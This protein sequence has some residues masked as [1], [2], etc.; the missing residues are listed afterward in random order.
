MLKRMSFADDSEDVLPP[1]Y[2]IV[3]CA[4]CGLTYDDLPVSSEILSE[5][6]RGATKYV[7]PHVGG[8]G[9]LSTVDRMRYQDLIDFVKPF[10]PRHDCPVADVGCGKG[11]LLRW[12]R[13]N[14]FTDVIGFEPSLG[15]VEIMRS[16]DI[17]AVCTDIAHLPG[18]RQY[19]LV[20]VSNV[21]E[22]LLAP[23]ES[24]RAVDALVRPGGLVCVEVPDGSRYAECFMAPYYSFDMEHINHFDRHALANLWGLAGYRIVAWSEYVGH[25]VPERQIPM[26]RILLEKTGVRRTICPD[27]LAREGVRRFVDLSEAVERRL[28]ACPLPGNLCYW[29]CG[30][31]AKWLLTR[32]RDLPLGMPRAI[33]DKGAGN[34][35]RVVGGVP[36]VPP[37][38]ILDGKD[39]PGILITSVL[40][41]KE[42]LSSLLSCGWDGGVWLAST[43][44]MAMRRLKK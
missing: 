24:A 6:Y 29:G 20:V 32:F 14:G 34:S 31:Y 1:R 16:H 43:G 37:G 7:Q 44:E 42:I 4:N 38:A 30:A 3:S 25:P 5:H 17:P 23:L 8:S 28:A 22:H 12:F 11:G 10:L 39:R 15:C 40:Y 35:G 19:G 21:F 13:E 18:D 9:D 26:V 41:E 2:D 36:V 27:G 33:I